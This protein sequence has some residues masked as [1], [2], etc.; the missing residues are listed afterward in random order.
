M[1]EPQFLQV[2]VTVPSRELGTSIASQL[3]REQLAGCVQLV[4]PILSVYRWQG[5]VESGEEWLLLM[6]TD[7]ATWPTLRDRVAALH[8]YD[9]P[10]ILGV[11]I[12]EGHPPY[13]RWLAESL[14]RGDDLNR[15]TPS[16]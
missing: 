15:G 14:S 12:S 6:K 7:A 3:V 5:Q 8:P 11:P 2:F 16:P 4:G 13:L 10:E 1:S 9:V